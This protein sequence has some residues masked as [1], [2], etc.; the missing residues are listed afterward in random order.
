MEARTLVIKEK[1]S[2]LQRARRG[3]SAGRDLAKQT[4]VAGYPRATDCLGSHNWLR[5]WQE[6]ATPLRGQAR[7]PE[8]S[9]PLA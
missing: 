8:G 9:K 3:G 1:D 4:V 2:S 7:A 6:G 5:G